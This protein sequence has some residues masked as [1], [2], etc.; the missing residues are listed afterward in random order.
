MN[1][2]SAQ[3][4]TSPKTTLPYRY[5]PVNQFTPLSNTNWLFVNTGSTAWTIDA[6]NPWK[7]SIAGNADPRGSGGS[8]SQIQI[9]VELVSYFHNIFRVYFDHQGAPGPKQNGP[10]TQQNLDSIR[11]SEI[12]KGAPEKPFQING[13]ELKFDTADLAIAFEEQFSC[14]VRDQEGNVICQDAKDSGGNNL[15]G[16]FVDS[17]FG[18][19]SAAAKAINPDS[20]R[21]Y[22]VGEVNVNVNGQGGYYVVGKS[23]LSMTNFN[24]DQI[25]YAHPELL[26]QGYGLDGTL[27]NYYF[28]MYFSAPWVINVSNQGKP[29]QCAYGIYLD[30][31]AQS[32]VNTGDKQFGDS[33]GNSNVLYVGSQSSLVDYYFVYGKPQTYE[34]GIFQGPAEVV[35]GLAYLC[36]STSD[37]G[38]AKYAAMPPK[39]I[40]GYFQG[41]YGAIGVNKNAYPSS[42]PAI[43]NAIFFEDVQQGYQG[44]S[45]PLEGLAVDIDVQDTYKVFTINSRFFVDGN[46]QGESIFQWAHDQGLVTQTNIT[47]FVKDSEGDYSVFKSLVASGLYTNNK[48]ADGTE[49]KTDGFGPADAYCGQLQYGENEKV[50]AIF[51]DWGK[52]GTG[53]WWGPNYQTLIEKGLDFVWQDM[54]TP[55]MD[56]HVIGNDV[57]DDGFDLSQ[58]EKA[59]AGN[60]ADPNAAAYAE[61]FNW[62]SY[63][64]SLLVT[65]PRFGDGAKR[66]FAE[67]RNQ[68]AYLLCQATYVNAVT[69][70]KFTKFQRSYII[71]RG[72]Q[73]GSQHF[74]GL[75]MGDNQSDWTHLNLMVPM[76]VSMN[77]SGMSIVGA[78]IGGFAQAG[79]TGSHVDPELLCRW[80]QAGCLLPWFRNH[81]DRYISLDPSTSDDPTQ[82]KPKG[83]GKQFQELYNAAYSQ[84]ADSMKMALELR[85]RWQEVLYT[86]AYLYASSGEPMVKAM[87]MWYGDSNIDFGIKPELNSQFLLGGLDGM[88]ILAAPVLTESQTSREVYF[89][90][91]ANWFPYYLEGDTANLNKYQPGGVSASVNVQ[92][93]DFAVYVREGAM[94]PTRYTLDGSVKPINGYAMSDPLV[95]DI[96]GA[97]KDSSGV[98][99]LDDGGVTRNA[100]TQG[101]YALLSTAILELDANSASIGATYVNDK[102]EWQG[103]IFFRLRA[104][105]KISGIT[106][107]GQNVP[108]S[109]AQ[110]RG[111]FFNQYMGKAYYWDDTETG[112]VWVRVPASSLS[113]GASVVTI[114]CEDQINVAQ[115]LTV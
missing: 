18:W 99:Y 49:F 8:A 52:D 108:N 97:I 82:W 59:N 75:W 4:R 13:A 69:K 87:C 84:Y 53:A 63:H 70:S 54:T 72:G 44:A 101:E 21:Q 51:P 33:V 46:P 86:A 24:Y 81:Y 114:E 26:P 94:I 16:T 80:V 3:V 50:T 6:D 61:T 20:D 109:N 34:A 88:Q 102:Y 19:A 57:T 65:D 29:N 45:M 115:P 31:I 23:G 30:N 79:D 106:L 85:Y 55:S 42:D 91:G 71:A 103:D 90:A 47:C 95:I 48:G 39:Y 7:C 28:P 93:N 66:S 12:A 78:D 58:L 77:M 83:H 41:I 25:T 36:Q 96:F 98:C 43:E 68:H 76:I 112:S 22:G 15:G 17:T 1:S 74:G 40:F 92:V 10:V 100:E 2:R 9:F 89:P 11:Q 14:T 67:V 32:Y 60:D 105:G 107:N 113:E 73:I 38:F 64:P 37:P 35:K 111:N 56:T 104:V 27:P 5:V 62:R 110:S